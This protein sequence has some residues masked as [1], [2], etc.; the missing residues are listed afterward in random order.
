MKRVEI[1]CVEASEVDGDVDD[2]SLAIGF[3]NIEKYAEE[4]YAAL[5]YIEE[6]FG[7]SPLNI[8]DMSVGGLLCD[9]EAYRS[10][11]FD[12]E[13]ELVNEQFEKLYK[14][15]QAAFLEK[16]GIYVEMFPAECFS[17]E[18]E[19]FFNTDDIG[20]EYDGIYSYVAIVA[21]DGEKYKSLEDLRDSL[22]IDTV[23]VKAIC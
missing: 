18:E 17:I 22:R 5:R 2:Y 8:C 19:V 21:Y 20:N 15:I 13:R 23:I 3:S 11:M 4:E 16:L 10:L 7:I 9:N 6:R 14:L 1:V 12:E